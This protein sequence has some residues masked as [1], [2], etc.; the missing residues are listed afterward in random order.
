MLQT[1]SRHFSKYSNFTNRIMMVEPTHYFVNEETFL[2]NKFMHRVSDPV[3]ESTALALVEFNRLKDA[4][5]GAGITVE[6]HI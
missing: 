3:A 4:I 1:N 2:D 5:E 6:K